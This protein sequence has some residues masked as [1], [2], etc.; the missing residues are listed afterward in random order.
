MKF[1]LIRISRFMKMFISEIFA[2]K[3]SLNIR[4]DPAN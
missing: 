2:P 3:H 1:E 4:N